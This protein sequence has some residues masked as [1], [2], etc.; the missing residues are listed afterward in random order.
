MPSTKPPWI[1]LVEEIKGFIGSY[2]LFFLV[3]KPRCFKCSAE[4]LLVFS[5]GSSV[6][7]LSITK[8]VSK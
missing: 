5:I 3:L 2:P 4:S 1:V 7:E 8:C 6:Q